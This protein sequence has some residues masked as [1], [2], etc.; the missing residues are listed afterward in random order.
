MAVIDPEARAYLDLTQ[1]LGLPPLA[2]QG[3][4]DARRNNRMR[5]KRLARALKLETLV[6]AIDLGVSTVETDND[7]ENAPILHINEELGYE[8]MPGKL[9]FHRKLT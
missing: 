8:E 4:L 7:S 3:V 6:Q 2:E 5:G 1:S 9:E